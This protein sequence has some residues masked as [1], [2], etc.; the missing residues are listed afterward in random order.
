MRVQTIILFCF[1]LVSFTRA[2]EQICPDTLD[3]GE[4]QTEKILESALQDDENTIAADELT[5]LEDDPLNLNS[6]SV[7]ELHRIPMISNLIASRI[8]E[9]RRQKQW[10][11]VHELLEIE[12]MTPELFS[13][14]RRYVMIEENAAHKKKSNNG[15][16]INGTFLSRMVTE[17]EERKGYSDGRY[18]GSPVKVLNRLRLS[19]G[20]K[21]TP[22]SSVVSE[23]DIGF[24][25][26]KDPGEPGL[27]NFTSYFAGF[28]I[29]FLASH[30]IV[31]HYQIE[32][33]EGLIFW[34]ASAF[35]KGSDVISPARKNGSGIHPSLSSDE[36]SFYRGFSGSMDLDRIQVQVFYSRKPINAVLDSLGNISSI[37]K[38]GLF[39]T[40]SELRNQ[41]S[42]RETL[43]GCRAVTYPAD[44]L[45]IA[46]TVSRTNYA[47]AFTLVGSR[48]GYAS[49]LWMRGLDISWTGRTVDVFSECAFD[50]VNALSVIAGVMVQP[51][52]EI[53]LTATVRNYS[54]AFQSRH[55]NA[56]GEGQGQ[57]QN[58]KGVYAGVRLQP[59]P[60]LC[61]SSYYD[62]FE[63]PLPTP[64]L[65]S[66][67]HGNDFLLLAEYS[68]TDRME[69]GFRYKRKEVPSVYNHNDI[70]GRVIKGIVP[71]VHYNYRLR[72]EFSSSPYLR[73]SSRVEWVNLIGNGMQGAEKGLLIS[74]G[75]K[76]S[77]FFPLTVQ[78]RFTIFGTESYNSAIYEFEEDVPGVYL[79]PALFGRGIRWYI[80]LRYQIYS[81]LYIAGKFAQT[82]KDGVKSIGTGSDEVNG[83]S[84]SVLSMQVEVRF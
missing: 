56:F 39:R 18:P 13:S 29:P 59:V 53:V 68:L 33:A 43:I 69:F 55:G 80:I 51:A 54:P 30:F 38:S 77:S 12:G 61:F 3:F 70:Y 9:R 32:A 81:K 84:Q 75:I 6:A 35:G 67:S 26:K 10:A 25:I 76:W 14:L 22:L 5:Q 60:E 4:Y 72:S 41:N 19:I 66:P 57:V 82:V 15:L 63:H 11:S 78:M 46:G 58:E 83:G 44:G 37:L 34:K 24:L 17:I 31:G 2:Q 1:S 36:N 42:S 71:I 45:K 79:S 21:R 52:S 50:R 65:P 8:V 20:K 49:E 62:Q 73:L 47:N 74:Q 27:A 7:E 40:E 16:S 23:L 28:S 48:S 64:R